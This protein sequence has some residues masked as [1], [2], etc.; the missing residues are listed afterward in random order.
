MGVGGKVQ[1]PVSEG[2]WDDQEAEGGVL[3]LV[4]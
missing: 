4:H 3:N 1:L 2:P